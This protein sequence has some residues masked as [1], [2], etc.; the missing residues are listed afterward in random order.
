MLASLAY[1]LWQAG[2]VGGLGAGL[3]LWRA[4][5]VPAPLQSWAMRVL[6][7]LRWTTLLALAAGLA[8]IAS[9]ATRI[10]GHLPLANWPPWHSLLL[11]TRLGQVWLCKQALLVMMAVTLFAGRRAARGV[12]L[13]C[14]GLA[15][16]FLVAGAWAGHGGVSAPLAVFLPLHGLHGIVSAAWLGALPVWASLLASAGEH[17]DEHAYLLHALQRF[18][19]FALD[20]MGVLVISGC[21]I[22]WR[23]F[24][25]WP[26]LFA[27]SAAVLL[28]LKIGLLAIV[29]GSAWR[30]RRDH[31]ARLAADYGPP[32]RRAALRVFMLE[33]CAAA[34]LFA[35]ALELAHGTPGA[36]QEV[37]WWLPFRLLPEALVNNSFAQ[38]QLTFALTIAACAWPAWSLRYHKL[39]GCALA[40]GAAIGLQAVAV[41]AFP[42]TYTRPTVAYGAQSIARGA[43]LYAQHCTG[44]HGSGGRGD[45][46]LELRTSV[47]PA[48]L[49]QHTALHS[50]GDMFAWL[51]DGTPSGAMPG[52]A[53]VLDEQQRWDLINLLRAFADGYRARVLQTDIQPFRPWLAAPNFQFQGKDG[54]SGELQGFRTQAAVLLVFAGTSA[55]G[56]QLQELVK[57]A[58]ASRSAGLHIVFVP[59]GLS[60]TNL[61]ITND[62]VTCIAQGGTAAATAYGLLSRTLAH[63][64]NRQELVP[65]LDDAAFLIDRYGYLRARWLPGDAVACWSSQQLRHMQQ[66]LSHEPQL[67]APPELHVH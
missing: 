19:R 57:E 23:Q 31:L 54:A 32:T 10:L 11:D 36:H 52:F 27:T 55:A 9:D 3:F 1:L 65:T 62:A 50:A 35:V 67:R 47:A 21:L 16:T 29:F 64:G 14:V 38:W 5:D 48:D 53:A 12:L 25:S 44:C 51:S 2:A 63:P 8:V 6:Q 45:G 49:A 60:C 4:G 34:V 46:E 43:E 33:L 17:R 30:L 22:A 61:P 39:A 66:A 20:A 28:W 42:S 56:A 24:A 15:S 37:R 41:R 40:L 18:S 7:G 59:L 26:A 58:S 13:A